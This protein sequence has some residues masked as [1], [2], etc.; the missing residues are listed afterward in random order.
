M[1]N[2]KT[3]H[4]LILALGV[5]VFM[6]S[7]SFR[8]GAQQN[9][10]S[11]IRIGDLDLGGVVTSANGPEAGVWV[12]AETSDLATKFAKIV[13]TDDQGRYVMPD[14]PKANYSEWVRGY[15]LDRRIICTTRSPQTSAIRGSMRMG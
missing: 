2:A 12:I 8:L 14:L 9:N 3:I 4:S 13:V 10:D 6:S 11:A 7:I 15:G 1:K 5:A